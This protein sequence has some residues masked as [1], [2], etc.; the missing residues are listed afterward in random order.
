MT[1]AVCVCC[2]W[3]LQALFDR[4]IDAN[5]LVT[6]MEKE[7]A[8][9]LSK[10]LVT[11]KMFAHSIKQRCIANPQRIVLPEVRACQ[12]WC[13]QRIPHCAQ[14]MLTACWAAGLGQCSTAPRPSQ[15]NHRSYDI[16]CSF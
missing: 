8:T 15:Y 11:P 7:E 9:V 14:L 2:L 3:L 13:R 16:L 12:G 5:S 4:Y 6:G 10:K 1:Q